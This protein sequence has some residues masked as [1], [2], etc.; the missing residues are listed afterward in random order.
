[1]DVARGSPAVRPLF[2][3]LAWLL[4][5]FIALGMIALVLVFLGEDL[6]PRERVFFAATL[7]CM[8]IFLWAS[9]RAALSRAAA[10]PVPQARLDA[11]WRVLLV[12]YVVSLL[13]VLGTMLEESRSFASW[14]GWLIFANLAGCAPFLLRPRAVT[15]R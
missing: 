5:G 7:F 8:A 11:W 9:V 14:A 10:T 2:R 15:G 13:V 12:V 1:M 3:L 4:A 6:P